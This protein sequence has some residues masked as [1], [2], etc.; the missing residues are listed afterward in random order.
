MVGFIDTLDE[1][2]PSGKKKLP[3]VSNLSE[4]HDFVLLTDQNKSIYEVILDQFSTQDPSYL[5]RLNRRFLRLTR[6]G[7]PSEFIIRSNNRKTNI[8]ENEY[9]S[10]LLLCA[11]SVYDIMKIVR[12]NQEVISASE[13]GLYEKL[14][15]QEKENKLLEKV[16]VSKVFFS[17]KSLFPFTN[18]SFYQLGRELS[19]REFY[20]AVGF[21][22]ETIDLLCDTDQILQEAERCE[23]GLIQSKRVLA[24]YSDP[25]S[26]NMKNVVWEMLYERLKPIV[27]TLDD[28]VVT[29]FN[30]YFN[31]QN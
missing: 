3:V 26:F 21:Q 5:S 6:Y 17:F 24:Q 4:E 31:Q 1:L 15:D 27:N 14:T 9:T 2:G 30:S 18:M 12:Y 16:R 29:I 8:T 20:S 22:D 25:K 19:D 28:N 10:L 13:S 7:D 11:T 23:M